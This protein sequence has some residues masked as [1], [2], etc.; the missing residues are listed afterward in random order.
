MTK[1]NI[2][3][4]E[5]FGEQRFD[6]FKIWTVRVNWVV[7]IRGLNEMTELGRPNCERTA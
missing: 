1:P 4:I 5:H 7:D 3:L 2:L 6:H